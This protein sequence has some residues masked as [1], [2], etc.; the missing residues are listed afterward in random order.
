MIRRAEVLAGSIQTPYERWG[1]GPPLLLLRGDAE[2]SVPEEV[3]RRLG[4]SYTVVV[5]EGRPWASTELSGAFSNWLRN[6]LDGLGLDQV[7]I[8]AARPEGVPALAFA[9]MEPDRVNTIVLTTGAGS[10]L[11]EETI[12]FPDR[13]ERSRV[14]LLTVSSD[15][16]SAALEA[17]MTALLEVGA[18]S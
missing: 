17:G 5:P 13:L 7:S 6:F 12:L 3:L 8:I 14:R 10:T 9:Q 16:P 15:D 2:A 1:Q 4:E 11:R 18:P